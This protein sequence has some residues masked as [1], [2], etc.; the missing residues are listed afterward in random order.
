LI[1]LVQ[2]M[3]VAFIPFPT[4]VLSQQGNRTATIFYALSMI[5]VGIISALMWWYAIHGNRLVDADLTPRQRRRGFL[6]NL[7]APAVFLVSI[8][9]AFIDAD[10]AKYSWFLIAPLSALMR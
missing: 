9:I 6:R 4:A 7:A 1:N 2:L 10:L 5:V 3:A 8:A